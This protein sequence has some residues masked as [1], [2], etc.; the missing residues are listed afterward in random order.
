MDL[1]PKRNFGPID[2]WGIFWILIIV[3]VVIGVAAI[4]SSMSSGCRASIDACVE[5]W[6]GN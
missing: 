5:Y 6:Q 2:W 3:V 1:E 4:A